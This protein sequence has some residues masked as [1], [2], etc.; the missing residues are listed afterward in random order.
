MGAAVLQLLWKGVVGEV[1]FLISNFF[2]FVMRM[3]LGNTACGGQRRWLR[4]RSKNW[5][6]VGGSLSFLKVCTWVMQDSWFRCKG[7]GEIR[8]VTQGMGVLLNSVWVQGGECEVGMCLMISKAVTGA[9]RDVFRGT[10]G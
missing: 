7:C 9:D 10:R 4:A 5:R 6:Y 8:V 3:G 1:R 2:R